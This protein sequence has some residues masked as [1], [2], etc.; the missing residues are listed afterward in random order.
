VVTIATTV[1]LVANV[2][3]QAVV[4]DCP[5][6]ASVLSGYMYRVPG[7]VRH[8]FPPNVDW[9]GWPTGRGQWTFFLRNA[10]SFGYTD[11]V[12]AGAVCANS[13]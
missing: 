4:V 3:T 5:A 12:E 13:N 7:G 1:T 6:G 8:P 10:N 2:G 11:S 9:T